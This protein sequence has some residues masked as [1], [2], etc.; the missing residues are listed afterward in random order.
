MVVVARHRRVLSIQPMRY[1]LLL[2]ESVDD[3]VS[4]VLQCCGEYHQLVVLRHL[5]DELGSER[6]QV[7]LPNDSVVFVVHQSFVQVK[8]QGVLLAGRRQER[9]FRLDELVV[10]F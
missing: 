3:P 6:P 4:V 5:F 7:E 2:I 1:P 9:R 8:D 10:D